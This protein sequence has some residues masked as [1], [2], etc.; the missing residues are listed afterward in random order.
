MKELL[1]TLTEKTGCSFISD[2]RTRPDAAKLA[3]AVGDVADCDYTPGEWSYA[4]SYITG[5]SLSFDTVAAAK[6]Y[7]RHMK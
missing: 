7:T 1:Q 3:Q 5:S 2:L 6:D 4:L